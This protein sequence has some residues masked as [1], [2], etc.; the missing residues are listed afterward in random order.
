MA[1]KFLAAALF[2]LLTASAAYADELI[3]FHKPGCRPCAHLK[4]ML[5]DNPDL[6]R[7][8]KVSRVD[9][10]QDHDSAELFKV[11]SVPTVVRLDDKTREVSRMVGLTGPREMAQWLERHNPK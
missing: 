1:K 9:V 2:C 11:S 4:K 7:G 6:V 5:D 3:V 10:S 8:F